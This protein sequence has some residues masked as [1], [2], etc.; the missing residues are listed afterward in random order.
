[1]AKI[2]GKNWGIGVVMGVTGIII[3]GGLILLL[4]IAT[5]NAAEQPDTATTVEG[6]VGGK[7]NVGAAVPTPDLGTSECDFGEWVGKTSSE[8]EAAAKATGRPYRI[9]PPGTAMTMDYRAD[10]INVET[11]GK[12]ASATVVKVF[13]G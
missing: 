9:L 1:M 13:C 3:L 8:A 5:P 2:N 7:T 10:R 12:D 6:N 11:S 4:N